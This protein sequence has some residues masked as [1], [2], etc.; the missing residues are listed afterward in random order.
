MN[1]I[2][3]ARLAKNLTGEQLGALVGVKKSAISKY[4]RDE[5][6]PS[7]DILF[8]MAD[9][10]DC[11]IDYLLGR[12]SYAEYMNIE[13]ST[14]NVRFIQKHV[15]DGEI[16]EADFNLPNSSDSPAATDEKK[17]AESG[18]TFDD[19]TYAMHSKSPRL[20]ERDKGILLSMADQFTK[21]VEKE[22][23]AE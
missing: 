18:I 3:K 20:S 19:F 13:V 16:T 17:T 15:D 23:E 4:E 11:S 7:K 2:R 8:A 22:E 12:T 21:D 9:E 14:G 10:L 6:Q 1:N 5:I